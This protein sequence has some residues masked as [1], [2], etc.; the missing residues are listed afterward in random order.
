M[1]RRFLWL[2]TLSMAVFAVLLGRLFLLTVLPDQG[3][4]QQTLRWQAKLRSR[5][6]LEHFHVVQVDDG[7]GRILFRNGSPW[8]GVESRQVL[9]RADTQSSS[10]QANLTTLIHREDLPLAD[11]VI[12]QVGKPDLWP[13]TRVVPEQGRSGLELTFDGYLQARRPG[14]FGLL[15]DVFGHPQN[16]PPYAVAASPGVNVRTTIDPA[17]QAA[18]AQSLT[19][20]GVK[21]G[22]IV[23]LA[24][25][26]NQILALANRNVAN[27][28]EITGV[29]AEVPGS[30][31]K[32]VT[33]AAALESFR[34]TSRS[35][36]VCLGRAQIPGVAMNCWRV[37][38]RESLREAFAGSCDVAFAQVGTGLT[39]KAFTL[40]ANKFGLMQTGIQAW[41]GA[42][43]LR[44]AE[45]GVLFRGGANDYGYLAN[46]AI[47]QQDVR[48]SPLQVAL[49]S[50]SVAN[51]GM[52][53][54]A[55]L[56]EDLEV[57]HRG[58]RYGG[59]PFA[60][61]AMSQLTASRIA[62]YMRLA[63]TSPLGTAHTL[64]AA[65]VECAVKTGTAEVGFSRVNG[66]VT[67]FAPVT[68]PKIAF[69][70][71]VGNES[72]ERAHQQ[73]FSIT[74]AILSAYSRFFPSEAPVQALSQ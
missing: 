20:T 19:T 23:V 74:R 11:P 30:V 3:H 2:F 37:H 64:L 33:T 55:Q 5:A 15:K 36:F 35:R 7:R 66:W 48:M 38:G 61:R 50:A 65:P 68:H 1:Q 39:R 6:D 22:A 69:C 16:L 58:I 71:Y 47:G 25:P 72:E 29:K 40:T 32:I 51:G 49:L 67:G 59:Q 46:T 24:L 44:E 41:D 13:G 4:L 52:Y 28:K 10:Q 17:W 26:S 14:Y 43:V 63:V 42:P 8:S 57:A 18:A 45:A 60:S 62:S 21:R 56:V 34:Y 12:G 31:F 53:R 70:V 27:Q 9:S 73:V 54:P